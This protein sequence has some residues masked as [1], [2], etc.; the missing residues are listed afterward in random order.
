VSE[1]LVFD[2]DAACRGLLRDQ[3]ADPRRVPAGAERLMRVLVKR[4]L[5]EDALVPAAALA[6]EL[7]RPRDREPS[8]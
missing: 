7:D 2:L 8:P 5:A 3:L 1:Q 6:L 4:G